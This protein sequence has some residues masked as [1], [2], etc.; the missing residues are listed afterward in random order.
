MCAAHPA[1]R[2]KLDPWFSNL[3]GNKK[4]NVF[5]MLSRGFIL[6]GLSSINISQG[7]MAEQENNILKLFVI[8][9]FIMFVEGL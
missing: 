1:V 6:W 8:Q 7:S 3:N 9:Q 2:K 4:F 5:L